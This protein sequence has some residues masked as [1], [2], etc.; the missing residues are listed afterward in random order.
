MDRRRC[1]QPDLI[2]LVLGAL[3]LPDMLASTATCRTWRA[4]YKAN[5]PLDATPFLNMN[6]WGAWIDGG[7]WSGRG[8]WIGGKFIG[9]TGGGWVDCAGGS[10]DRQGR[11]LVAG[12]GC[13]SLGQGTLGHGG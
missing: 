7:A 12:C 3:E 2:A 8:A 13:G 6:R 4:A 11:Q 5:P 9:G 1:L 10:F